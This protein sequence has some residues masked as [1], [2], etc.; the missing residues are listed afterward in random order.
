MEILKRTSYLVIWKTI[1][2]GLSENESLLFSLQ[3]P[4]FRLHSS[5]FQSL[6]LTKCSSETLQNFPYIIYTRT[7]SCFFRFSF[8]VTLY[9][10]LMNALV[11][12]DIDVSLELFIKHK[13]WNWEE[14]YQ[15]PNLIWTPTEN[16]KR[17][18]DAIR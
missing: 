4:L 6:C 5:Q 7:Q 3:S 9:F 10:Y 17:S 2:V 1:G 14:W 8:C 12:V 16:D 11:Y 15:D 18:T 13:L